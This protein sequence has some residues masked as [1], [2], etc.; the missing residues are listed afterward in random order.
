MMQHK[1]IHQSR[2][3]RSTTTIA[4]NK[5][6]PHLLPAQCIIC[7]RDKYFTDRHS[8]KRRKEHLQKCETLTGGKL[9]AAAEARKDENLLI[10]I[11]RKDLVA[12]E[13]MYHFRCYRDYTVF[14][15]NDGSNKDTGQ[16]QC[17]AGYEQFCKTVIDERVFFLN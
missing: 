16:S 12:S 6:K 7:R 1:R 10:H 8:K 15:Y 17:Q 11:R 3:L 9:L 14:L 2:L 5:D 4:V 13:A